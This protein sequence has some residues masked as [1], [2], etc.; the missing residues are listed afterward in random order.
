[1]DKKLCPLTFNGPEGTNKE[2]KEMRCAW[3]CDNECAI[4][5]IAHAQYRKHTK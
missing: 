4:K 3:W 5:T 2:C 1:M